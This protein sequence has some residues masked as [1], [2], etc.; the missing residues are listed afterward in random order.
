MPTATNTILNNVRPLWDRTILCR[1]SLLILIIGIH[2]GLFGCAQQPLSHNPQT[3]QPLSYNAHV[4][5]GAKLADQQKWSEAIAEYNQGIQ[6]DPKDPV[7][8][9][10]RGA[11]YYNRGEYEKAVADYS[12]D[13]ELSGGREPTPIY[14][15]GLARVNLNIFDAAIDDFT[16]AIALGGGASNYLSRGRAYTGKGLTTEAI[17]DFTRAIER[18]ATMTVAYGWRGNARVQLEQY[19]LGLEDLER[20]IPTNPTDNYALAMQGFALFKLGQRERAREIV[21]RLIEMDTRLAKNFSGER[22]A[23]IYDRDKRRAMVRQAL[24]AASQAEQSGE[25]AAAFQEYERARGWTMGYTDED[26]KAGESIQQGQT[27]L[28]PKLTV[29]P[30]LPEEAR[31]YRVQAEVAVREKKFKD[32]AD[33]YLKALAVAPWWPTATF[34]RAVVLGETG[35]YVMAIGAMKYYLQL[36]PDAP[37]ARAAQDRIY[38]WELKA[39]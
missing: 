20:Y 24:A 23:D 14:M 29:K 39:K 25:V 7:A 22:W 8:Y 6:Q 10:R 34:N 11:A 37:D 30:A 3:T 27:R 5:Q 15:R 4:A 38:E 17:A 13:I 35:D 31:K 1:R 18:D 36:A 33:L 28:Y 12:R 2:V 21:P 19:S 9:D 26:R 32:A 16:R